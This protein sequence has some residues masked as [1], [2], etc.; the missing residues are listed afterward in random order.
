VDQRAYAHPG[1]NLD[2]AALIALARAEPY[3]NPA[4][5]QLADA[6]SP[7]TEHR[8]SSLPIPLTQLIGRS[9]DLAALRNLLLRGELRLLTLLGPP[10]IGK[11]SLSIAVAHEVRP[12]FADG[13]SFVVLAPISDPGLVLTTIAQTL[14]VREI[15]GQPLL[16]TLTAALQT[17]R[18]LLVLYPVAFRRA[19]AAEMARVFRDVCRD[20][21][22]QRGGWG[23]V[24]L[25][26]A[27]LGDLATTAV[28]ERLAE[29]R[30]PAMRS[31]QLT[32]WCGLAGIGGGALWLLLSTSL[33][34]KW[35]VRR[36]SAYS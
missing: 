7:A 2:R 30:Q 13:V 3:Y 26:V 25:W 4:A 22:R 10:G 34:F 19:Y 1:A 17:R 8:S 11:T 23:V 15:A 20:V 14:G 27:T 28:V 12:A 31:V 21:W 24:A 16:E 6:S 9:Q 32:R 35:Q 33:A 18:L 29:R 36:T 5:A